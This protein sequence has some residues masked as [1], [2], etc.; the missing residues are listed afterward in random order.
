MKLVNAFSLLLDLRFAIVS[1]FIPTLKSVL[2][3]PLLLFR[4]GQLSR[5]FMANVWVKF[6][7][8]LDEG[9]RE[10]K[11]GLIEA[12]AYGVVLDI[13]AGHGHTAR[14]LNQARV[15]RYVALEPNKLMHS[16]IRARANEAGFF[17]SDGRLII[18]GCGAEDTTTILK[19]LDEPNA[20]TPTSPVGDRRQQSGRADTIISVLT[21]CT[22][23]E[24]EKTI[25]GLARDVLKSGGQLLYYEHVKSPREDVVWWQ[26]FWTPIWSMAFD[27]CKLDRPTDR[28]IMKL[29]GEGVDGSGDVE[30]SMW[31]EWKEWG[32]EG[33]DE[34]CLFWHSTGKFVKR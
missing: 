23:P 21:L 27:G 25:A 34:E 8:G 18:L 26:K 31:R 5:I 20:R 10:I 33:E 14:Y 29:R 3:N 9:I 22:V 30:G 13:G 1:A 6:G 19:A 11:R 4:P 12:N 16:E 32:K 2:L 7:S 15:T 17:E 24:P 28:W